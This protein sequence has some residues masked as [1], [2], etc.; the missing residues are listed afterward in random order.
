MD[1]IIILACVWYWTEKALRNLGNL[2]IANTRIIV[3]SR[4]EAHLE[5]N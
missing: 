5:T 2:K 3:Y 1:E 4:I